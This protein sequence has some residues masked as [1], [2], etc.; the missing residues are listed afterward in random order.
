[1]ATKPRAPRRENNIKTG[2]AKGGLKGAPKFKKY[3]YKR[4]KK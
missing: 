3:K 2:K 1:M 4:P